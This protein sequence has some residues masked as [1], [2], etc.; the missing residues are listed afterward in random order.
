MAEG[1]RDGK[2]F[3]L[4]VSVGFRR[5]MLPRNTKTLWA[6]SDGAWLLSLSGML[7]FTIDQ[8]NE[9]VATRSV[10]QTMRWR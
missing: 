8:P 4:D 7:E 3:D 10:P 5:V 9:N 1:V 2:I 6:K